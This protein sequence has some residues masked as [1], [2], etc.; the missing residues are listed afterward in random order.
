LLLLLLLIRRRKWDEGQNGTDF[1]DIAHKK[2][3]TV[4]KREEN[5]FFI[6][7]DLLYICRWIWWRIYIGFP[8]YQ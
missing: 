6:S 5:S 3:V 2:D 8:N 7:F 1:C 4:C